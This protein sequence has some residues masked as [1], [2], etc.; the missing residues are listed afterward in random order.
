M[1]LRCSKISETIYQALLSV[2]IKRGLSQRT[3]TGAS[4]GSVEAVPCKKAAKMRSSG[5]ELGNIRMV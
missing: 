2:L 1:V 5:Q 4:P 3:Q